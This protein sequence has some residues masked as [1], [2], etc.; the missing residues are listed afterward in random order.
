MVE[1]GDDL[2]QARD[3]EFAHIFDDRKSAAAFRS[4]ADQQGYVATVQDRGD[5]CTDVIVRR[6]MVPEVSAVT[7]V[8]LT[9]ATAARDHGGAPDGWGCFS[10]PKLH[11]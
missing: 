7:E 8:E 10:V 4:W 3:V 11:S 6:K 9:L 2:T 1:H 5:E